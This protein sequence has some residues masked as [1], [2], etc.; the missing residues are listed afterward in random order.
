VAGRGVAWRDSRSGSL[1]TRRVSIATGKRSVGTCMP[2]RL[3]I[4][5]RF[6]VANI[7]VALTV[8]II[9]MLTCLRYGRSFMPG[10]SSLGRSSGW[11]VR[12]AARRRIHFSDLYIPEPVRQQRIMPFSTPSESTNG[13][14][15]SGSTISSADVLARKIRT[16]ARLSEEK[17]ELDKLKNELV[18]ATRQ[19][20]FEAGKELYSKFLASG[21]HGNVN[22]FDLWLRLCQ[23]KDH[24]PQLHIYLGEGFTYNICICCFCYFRVSHSQAIRITVRFPPRRCLLGPF[25]MSCRCRR[26]RRLL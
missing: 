14:I 17:K 19:N 10:S 13:T 25:A 20:D 2:V 4:R 3:P 5:Q 9:I 22:L 16:K 26:L 12:S 15:S 7:R 21:L 6:G 18:A 11:I 1:N 23:K 24:L 8:A